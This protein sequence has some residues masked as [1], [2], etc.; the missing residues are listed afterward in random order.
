MKN[1]PTL[2]TERLTLRPFRLS[3]AKEVQR[4]AG[5]PKVAA[6][7]GTIPHPYPDGVAESWISQHQTWFEN[8]Q[9]VDWAIELN[10]SKSLVGCMSLGVNKANQRAEIGYWIGEESWGKGYCS[11]AAKAAIRYAFEEMNLNKIT[12]RHMLENPVSGKVMQNAGM[13][14]EG[15]LRQEFYK[16]GHFVDMVVYGLVRGQWSKS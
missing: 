14:Q 6:T 12:S 4:Q 7:T 5:N 3:D 9:A 11:E 16:N 2:K 13:V 10:G 15:T 8:G 1:I